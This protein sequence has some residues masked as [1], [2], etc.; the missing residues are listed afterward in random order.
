MYLPACLQLP[1]AKPTKNALTSVLASST[2]L[3]VSHAHELDAFHSC[4]SDV[5]FAHLYSS[6][7]I[8]RSCLRE[9][10]TWSASLTVFFSVLHS[11]AVFM[12]SFLGGMM[13]ISGVSPTIRA[14]CGLTPSVSRTAR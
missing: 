3:P 7:I 9:V 12:P 5:G 10:M 6:L 13:S 14:S 8:L 11:R 2:E 4:V 1:E